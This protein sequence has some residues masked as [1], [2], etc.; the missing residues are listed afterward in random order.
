[1]N[2][3]PTGRDVTER[4]LHLE[5]PAD[6]HFDD[7]VQKDYFPCYVNLPDLVDGALCCE[8]WGYNMTT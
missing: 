1:M 7:V 5:E 2:P 3:D 8:T 6:I 4:I